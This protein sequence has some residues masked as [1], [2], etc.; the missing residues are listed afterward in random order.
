MHLL[1]NLSCMVCG[2]WWILRV[3]YPGLPSHP[4]HHIAKQQMTGFGGVFSFELDGDLYTTAKFIDALR[5]PYLAPS[6]GRSESIIDQPIVMSYWLTRYWLKG[7]KVGT[8]ETFAI[9]PGLQTMLEPMKRVISG[10]QSIVG[11]AC[12]RTFVVCIQN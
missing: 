4:E 2:V 1:I 3:H 5:I 10:L 6:F 11:A 9:L 7:G 12:T 8:S